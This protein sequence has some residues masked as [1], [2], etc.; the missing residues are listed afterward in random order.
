MTSSILSAVVVAIDSKGNSAVLDLLVL[1]HTL[2]S[3]VHQTVPFIDAEHHWSK[4]WSVSS[5]ASL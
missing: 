4:D 1:E 3:E 2:N 5:L